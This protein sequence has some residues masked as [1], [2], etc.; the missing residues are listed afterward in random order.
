M[1]QN[2]EFDSGMVKS[3]LGLPINF[4][5]GKYLRFGLSCPCNL[6]H[7]L[8]LKSVGS[9]IDYGLL[10]GFFSF[11]G[12]VD[13]E[14]ATLA[15]ALGVRDSLLVVFT[16]CGQS[17]AA[18]YVI[19]VVA[20][21]FCIVWKVGVGAARNGL[22]AASNP[23]RLRLVLMSVLWRTSDLNSI[24]TFG[25]RLSISNFLVGCEYVIGFILRFLDFKITLFRH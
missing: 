10:S 19:T 4:D 3:Y 13:L 16:V 25:Q 2:V 11:S 22:V 20:H 7:A 14:I 12:V 21:T 18:I 23:P 1:S 5:C 8:G 17:F 24:A 15:L 9:L 6:I